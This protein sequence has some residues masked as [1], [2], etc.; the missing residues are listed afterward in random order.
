MLANALQLPPVRPPE[1][2]EAL[3]ALALDE[4]IRAC[5]NNAAC[6][7]RRLGIR[8]PSIAGWKKRGRVPAE[9][10]LDVERITGVSRHRLRCDIYGPEPLSQ[11]E[12]A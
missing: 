12:A 8:S 3:S 11:A 4:A 5:E 6:L 9:R 1:K 10:V 7:A 2:S